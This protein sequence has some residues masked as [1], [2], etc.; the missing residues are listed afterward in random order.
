MLKRTFEPCVPSRGTKVPTGQDWL[1]EVKY[2]G[3]RLIVQRDG[4]HVRLF[5]RNGHYWTD[6]YPLI[7][8]LARRNKSTSS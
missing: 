2:E 8:E 5:S 3:Y 7:V 4:K 1:H 6:R